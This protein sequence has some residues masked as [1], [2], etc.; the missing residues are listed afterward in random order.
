MNEKDFFLASMKK[1][2]GQLPL[3]E[4]SIDEALKKIEVEGG[5][6]DL[7]LHKAA[8]IEKLTFSTITIHASSVSESS[9]L[10]WPEDGYTLPLFWC[11]LT[12]MPGMNIF[13]NDF[14]PLTDIVMWPHYG[15]RYLDDLM[16]VKRS[17]AEELKE[18]MADKAFTLSTKTAWALSPHCTV[19]SLRDAVIPKLG[20]VIDQYCKLYLKLWQEAVLIEKGEE[21]QFAQRKKEAVRKMMKENDPGY[22][23][24]VNIFGEDKTRKVFDLIF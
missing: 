10:V 13:I 17:T 15:E 18:G 23:F 5:T 11:N 24:M 9:L 20:S 1:G 22:Y 19:F 14:T 3:Q 2:L 21:R 16:A 12:C 6:I 4:V 8:K 7:S